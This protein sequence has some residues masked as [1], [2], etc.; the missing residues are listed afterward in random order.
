[1]CSEKSESRQYLCP[2]ARIWCYDIVRV[3]KPCDIVRAQKP[4][5]SLHDDSDPMLISPI[6]ERAAWVSHLVVIV[7][8]AKT[9]YLRSSDAGI[10]CFLHAR[11]AVI[12]VSAK[13]R[14]DTFVAGVTKPYLTIFMEALVNHMILHTKLAAVVHSTSTCAT[15]VRVFAKTQFAVGFESCL[16]EGGPLEIHSILKPSR[17][18]EKF[19][20]TD[21]K[22]VGEQTG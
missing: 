11:G 20:E 7:I 2:I 5:V 4:Q 19:F 13:F 14:F 22:R 6:E 8:R 18:F 17:Q 10:C 9:G 3:Q 16:P 1:M 12:L 21:V 15:A